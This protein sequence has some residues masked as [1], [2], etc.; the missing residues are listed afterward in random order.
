[1]EVKLRSV[2]VAYMDVNRT[3]A[4]A[5]AIVPHESDNGRPNE[6]LDDLENDDPSYNGVNLH[7]DPSLDRPDIR[8]TSPQ[9]P[10][11]LLT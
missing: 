9:L 10:S 7:G 3:S 11:N 6:G 2:Y 4:D 5:G 1:M 8:S